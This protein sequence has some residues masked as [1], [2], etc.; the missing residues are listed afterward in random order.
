M[1]VGGVGQTFFA[2]VDAILSFL[3]DRWVCS[4]FFFFF[5]G[6]VGIS[7][8]LW[9]CSDLSFFLPEQMR[10]V[11]FFAGADRIDQIW[12]GEHDYTDQA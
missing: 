11:K 8:I 7:Q 1:G 4:N 2:G 10:L 6:L 9:E 5:V 3:Q 12:G